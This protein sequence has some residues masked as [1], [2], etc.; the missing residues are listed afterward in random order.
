MAS[1]TGSDNPRRFTPDNRIVPPTDRSPAAAAAVELV[2]SAQTASREVLRDVV[3]RH[4]VDRELITWN[5]P[6]AWA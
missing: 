3:H 6:P 5:L 1:L 4:L 2:S